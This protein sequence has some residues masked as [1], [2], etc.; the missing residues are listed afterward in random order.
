MEY[1]WVC[2]VCTNKQGKLNQEEEYELAG[3]V[4]SATFLSA[5]QTVFFF[6]VPP[7][8]MYRYFILTG[9]YYIHCYFCILNIK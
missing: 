3:S 2:G 5:E 8:K 7:R 1:G 9:M 6:R 4:T